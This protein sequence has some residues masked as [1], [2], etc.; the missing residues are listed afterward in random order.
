MQMQDIF[1]DMIIAPSFNDDAL[2][3]LS[4]KKNLILLEVGSIRNASP[5]PA[6]LRA[7]RGGILIQDADEVCDD[8]ASWKVAGE[9][10]P[11]TALMSDALFGWKVVKH[12][13]SN[14]IAVV[15]DGQ[16]L[17]LGMGQ[18]NRVDA[19]HIA[20]QQAGEKAKGAVLTSDAMLP[21]D[22]T[23]KLAS[24]YGVALIVQTGGSIRDD[25]VIKC[26]DKNAIAMLFTGV[27]HFKH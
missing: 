26:A 27:R 18:V 3:L 19:A 2:N 5:S 20:L 16:T 17:G 9:I 6:Q 15:K 7:I 13:H 1:L 8:P 14:A 21:F 24:Q 25:E 10:E 4:K 23:V 12:M 11:P 22:D